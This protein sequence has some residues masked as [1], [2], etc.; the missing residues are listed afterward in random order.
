MS[1]HGL[2]VTIEGLSLSYG[3]RSAL[4]DV[5]LRLAPGER[6]CLV[7]P[8]G[9]GK[10][11]LLRCLTGLVA[12]SSG[13]VLLDGT[14]VSE[15]ER[16]VLA[17]QL[18]VVP[19]QVELPFSMRVDEVVLLGRIP[20]EHPFTGARETDRAAASAAMTRVGIDHLRDRDIRALSLGE[21]QLVLV[22]VALAQGG[23]LLVLDEPTVH[24]DLRHQVEVLSLLTRLSEQDGLTVLAVLHDLSMAAHF[25]PRLIL[26][27]RGRVVADGPAAEV[28]TPERIRAVYG[29][30][31]RYVP[32]L[33]LSGGVPVSVAD[34]AR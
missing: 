29:V 32:A 19:G 12:A 10:S 8:N 24:L 30:D 15:I 5:R 17:R 6:A 11:S 3:R 18:S 27:D 1:G 28:L 25:F 16:P 34:P 9:A 13:S 2:S 14:P 33:A 7:G 23:R 20:H 4:A 26:L 31:P 22:A 21:R